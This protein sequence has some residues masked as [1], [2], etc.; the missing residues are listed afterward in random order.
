MTA[1]MEAGIK[2]SRGA[3]EIIKVKKEQG[4]SK[5]KVKKEKVV[6]ELD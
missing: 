5:A 1:K 6:I 4:A 3:E 2:R